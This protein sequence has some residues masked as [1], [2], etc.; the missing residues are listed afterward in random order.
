MPEF[1][2]IDV[3]FKNKSEKTRGAGSERW[4]DGLLKQLDLWS[5]GSHT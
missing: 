3:S 4:S 5:L 1:F 2:G